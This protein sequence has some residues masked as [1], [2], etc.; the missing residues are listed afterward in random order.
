MNSI[1]YLLAYIIKFINK[2]AEFAEI[3]EFAQNFPESTKFMCYYQWQFEILHFIDKIEHKISNQEIY[4]YAV[5][6]YKNIHI[7]VTLYIYVCIFITSEFLPA[8]ECE[9]ISIVSVP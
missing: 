6:L 4:L 5:H 8:A 1:S 7:Y 2:L 3:P 9:P